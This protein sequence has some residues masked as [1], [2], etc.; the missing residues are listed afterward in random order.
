MAL[1]HTISLIDNFGESVT[2]PNTY[3]KV[4]SVSSTKEMCVAN[5]RIFKAQ[6]GIQLKEFL[7]EFPLDLDGPNPIKQAYQFLKTLPE[8]FDATDC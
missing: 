4:F 7:T 3:I 8:F 2:F 5:C 1:S 6:N